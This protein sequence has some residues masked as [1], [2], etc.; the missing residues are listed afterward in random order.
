MS[1]N[2][3]FTPKSKKEYFVLITK[4][5]QNKLNFKKNHKEKIAECYYM[6]FLHNGDYIKNHSRVV[7][8]KNYLPSVGQS[9][10][11]EILK[12]FNEGLFK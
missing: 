9:G 7:N 3:V 8:L 5:I 10:I 11:Y 4:A 12:K 1:Y 2:F 6:Y